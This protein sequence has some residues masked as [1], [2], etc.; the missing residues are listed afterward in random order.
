MKRMF[1]SVSAVLAVG[2]LA[3]SGATGAPNFS[4]ADGTGNSPEFGRVHVNVKDE[5]SPKG[6]FFIKEAGADG[7]EIT[8][9]VVHGNRA[10]VGG[11]AR[12][13]RSFVIGI[14]DNGEPG[15][16]RDRMTWRQSPGPP[17]ES[18]CEG[19]T[20]AFFFD[21]PFITQGNYVVHDAQ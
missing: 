11:V 6:H 18:S 21:Q 3:T 2:M 17:P 5:A 12:D 15:A 16:G 20:Q 9:F 10:G 4:K 7:H 13:G 1:V 19:A 14:E 8:C